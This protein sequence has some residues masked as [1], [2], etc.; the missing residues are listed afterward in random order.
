MSQVRVWTDDEKEEYHRQA[1]EKI[2][3]EGLKGAAIIGVLGNGALLAANKFWPAYARVNW[4]GKFFLASVM[5]VI[6]YAIW[7]DEATTHYARQAPWI[8]DEYLAS[9]IQRR[10]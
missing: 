6:G 8:K 2:Q 3:Q 4:R 5:P 9:R 1:Q 7:G 10:D